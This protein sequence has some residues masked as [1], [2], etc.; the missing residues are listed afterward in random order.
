MKETEN[1]Q[2]YNLLETRTEV[3][4]KI[5]KVIISVGSC[6]NLTSKEMVDKFSLKLLKHSYP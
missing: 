6:H 1:G 5:C 4:N 2:R 3:E